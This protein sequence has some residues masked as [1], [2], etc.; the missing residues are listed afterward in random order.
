M[1]TTD[2]QNRLIYL[3][4]DFIAGR[5]EILSGVSPDTQI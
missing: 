1:L 3:D 5:F 2:V 4:R